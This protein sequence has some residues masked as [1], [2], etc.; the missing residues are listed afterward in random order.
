MTDPETCVRPLR[1]A[2]RD[3][4]VLPGWLARE[5]NDVAMPGRRAV[6]E[7]RLRRMIEAELDPEYRAALRLATDVLAVL[8]S[9]TPHDPVAVEPSTWAKGCGMTERARGG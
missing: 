3:Q 8:D 1:P 9:H 7:L 2:G 5:L 6:V 4:N